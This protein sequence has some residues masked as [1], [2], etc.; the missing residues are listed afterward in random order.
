MQ[1]KFLISS[2]SIFVLVCLILVLLLLKESTEEEIIESK[3]KYI[4]AKSGLNLRSAPDKLSKVVSAIPFGEKV[5]IEK[6]DGEKIFLDERYGKWVSVKFG[7]KK[8]WVFSGFLCDFKPDSII[9]I[10]AD[11]YRNENKIGWRGDSFFEPVYVYLTNFKDSEVSI[12]NIFDNNIVLDIPWWGEDDYGT[13]YYVV[14]RYDP[15]REK[16]FEAYGKATD[17]EIHLLYLDNDKY[18]DLVVVHG[19]DGLSTT[20]FLLGSKNGFT[21]IDAFEAHGT[22]TSIDL[23]NMSV[24]VKDKKELKDIPYPITDKYYKARENYFENYNFLNDLKNYK[25]GDAVSFWYIIING[26]KTIYTMHSPD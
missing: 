5:I 14:W 8:G 1:K 2:I 4:A 22:I 6:S 20:E 26:E 11:Y 10:A 17:R 15:K 16:F 23:K 24:V 25:K 19:Y 9:K 12:V 3:E 21:K 7:N 13:G 18:P